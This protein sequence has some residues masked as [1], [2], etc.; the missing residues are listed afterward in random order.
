MPRQP[1]GEGAQQEILASAVA[2]ERLRDAAVTFK[3][4][5]GKTSGTLFSKAFNNIY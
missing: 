4:A 5:P 3:H 1:G 2:A